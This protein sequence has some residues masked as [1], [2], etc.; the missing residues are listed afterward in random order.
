MSLK[1]ADCTVVAD[2]ALA[3]TKI[4][5]ERTLGVNHKWRD[6]CTLF[7]LTESTLTMVYVLGGRIKQLISQ[8]T[9]NSIFSIWQAFKTN[10]LII[11]QTTE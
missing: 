11:S 3:D 8:S 1:L 2:A 4:Q 9:D 10:G 7:I 5:M 6:D